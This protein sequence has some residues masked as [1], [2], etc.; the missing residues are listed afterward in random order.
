VAF[1]RHLR[2]GFRKLRQTQAIL[3]LFHGGDEL[4]GELGLGGVGRSECRDAGDGGA[5]A[6]GEI[7]RVVGGGPRQG[8]AKRADQVVVGVGLEPFVEVVWWGG[9]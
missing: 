8:E 1:L 3:P 5:V 2:R 6:P 9:S 7:V 4:R